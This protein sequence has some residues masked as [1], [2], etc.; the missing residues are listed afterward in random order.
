MWYKAIRE[1][2]FFVVVCVDFLDYSDRPN[3]RK[4]NAV[5]IYQIHYPSNPEAEAIME[6]HP[7]L[8]EL[9]CI[10]IEKDEIYVSIGWTGMEKNRAIMLA[11]LDSV[12]FCKEGDNFLVPIWWI[13][14]VTAGT[15][16]QQAIVSQMK[17][18]MSE[19]AAGITV[20]GTPN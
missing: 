18:M 4:E 13:E 8:L 2:G 7:V 6:K 1:G 16:E 10:G 14:K 9:S 20:R 17:Q 15:G 11:M 19:V 3:N 12:S 5:D